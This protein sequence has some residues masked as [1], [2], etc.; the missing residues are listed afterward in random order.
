L[1]DIIIY[2]LRLIFFK[3]ETMETTQTYNTACATDGSP[4][5]YERWPVSNVTR[6][7]I[8]QGGLE[9]RG[10]KLENN[11]F[12]SY[13]AVHK[14]SYEGHS[15]VMRWVKDSFLVVITKEDNPLLLEGFSKVIGQKPFLRYV[16]P[17]DG[18]L[19]FEWDMKNPE[20]R[21][22]Q[23]AERFRNNGA[24]LRWIGEGVAP[25]TNPA[26]EDLP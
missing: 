10:L 5:I 8:E 11:G 1:R 23:L 20:K 16:H 12:D 4:I 13:L 9:K 14:G 15:F 26:G 2:K 17:E 24:E 22:L 19:T 3:K 18:M 7:L 6:D 21:Y 25:V